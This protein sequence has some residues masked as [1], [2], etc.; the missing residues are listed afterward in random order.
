MLHLN[1]NGVLALKYLEGFQDVSVVQSDH[2]L[3]FVD[4]AQLLKGPSELG[5]MG[6]REDYF[7][8]WLFQEIFF[9]KAFDCKLL[10]AFFV[11]DQMD[12]FSVNLTVLND[13]LGL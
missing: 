4:D 11:L 10:F 7:A 2:C 5:G 3:D 9:R 13:K 8:I 6:R 12:L 1:V